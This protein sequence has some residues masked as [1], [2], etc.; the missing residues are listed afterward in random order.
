MSMFVSVHLLIEHSHYLPVDVDEE[1]ASWRKSALSAEN[2]TDGLAHS[3]KSQSL[4]SLSKVT[5]DGE[6]SGCLC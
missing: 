3:K 1:Y 6:W 2:Q 4:Q 5:V